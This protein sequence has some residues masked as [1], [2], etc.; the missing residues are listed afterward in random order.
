LFFSR[1]RSSALAGADVALVV[2]VPLDFRLGFGSVFAA[3]AELVVIDVAEP[4]REHPRPVAAELYGALPATLEALRIGA[5]PAGGAMTERERW[6]ASLRSIEQ[7]K[8]DGERAELEDSR[9]PLHPM[10]IYGELAQVLD[11][12]AIVVGDGGDFVSYAGRVVDSYQPG[13]LA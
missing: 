1:A 10:R 4:G 9:A 2:G 12:D 3:D 5:A 8:R 7:E 13:V 11:R 6:L